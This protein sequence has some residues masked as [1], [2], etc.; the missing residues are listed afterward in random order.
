MAVRLGTGRR[1]RVR[2]RHSA[3]DR[4]RHQLDR[5]RCRVRPRAC[6]RGRRARDRSVPRR[7]GR[8]RVHEVRSPVAPGWGGCPASLRPPA[9]VDPTGMRGQPP[10]PRDRTHRPLPVP[11][12]GHRNGDVGRGFM[13]DDGRARPGG[14]GAL[15]RCLELQRRAAREVRVDPPRRLAAAA[16]VAAEPARPRGADSLVHGERHGCG[17]LLTSGL[18]SSQRLVSIP[19]ASH[20]TTGGPVRRASRSQS[21]RRRSRSSS[22][23]DRSQHASAATCQRLP[24]PGCWPCPV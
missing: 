24:S 5:Q 22:A 1:R 20:R 13:G 11:L 3:R 4:G 9:R 6:R 16:P 19:R 15:D 8:P 23:C 14:Q 10:A 7:G 12:A 18:G 2:G 21:S 17:R